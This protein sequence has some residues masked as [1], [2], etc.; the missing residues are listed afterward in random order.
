[1]DFQTATRYHKLFEKYIVA[2][3]HQDLELLGSMMDNK[4]QLTDWD[5]NKSGKQDVLLANKDIWDAVPDIS[6]KIKSTAYNLKYN[7][8]FAQITVTS[9]SQDLNLNV[10]DVVTFKGSS[11]L[12]VEA[13]KQ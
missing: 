9:K 2:W 3:N 12:K 6:I 5:V 7:Q 8:V 11:I 4:V 10:V 1:M 13:Y